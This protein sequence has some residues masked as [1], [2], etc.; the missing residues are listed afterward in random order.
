VL[1]ETAFQSGTPCDLFV[2]DPEVI[3]Q[4]SSGDY[5]YD[6]DSDLESISDEDVTGVKEVVTVEL[7]ALSIDEEGKK[8]V[9][10][11]LIFNVPT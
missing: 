7:D 1:S 3:Q 11:I 6:S 8:Y 4:L 10:V 9:F 2:D 5:G